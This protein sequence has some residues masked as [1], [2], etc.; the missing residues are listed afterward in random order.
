[1]QVRLSARTLMIVLLFSLFVSV[2]CNK[3]PLYQ[4]ND[5][6]FPPRATAKVKRAILDAGKSLGWRMES[7]GAGR[8]QA[9]IAPRGHK[10]VVNIDYTGSRFTIKYV[11]SV[12]LHYENTAS[13][14]VIHKNY[15]NWVRRLENRIYLNLSE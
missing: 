10:A 5:G 14:E 12:D 15:N 2:G 9:T 7:K 4:V 3:K 6:S 1:M 13:G 8:I 11:S